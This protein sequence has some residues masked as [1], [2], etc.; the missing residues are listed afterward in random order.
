MS[1]MRD[2]PEEPLAGG[3]Q[4][5]GLVRVGST[6]RRPRHTQSEFV[7]ALLGHLEAVG[8][9]GAPRSLGYDKQGRQVLTYVEG[10]VPHATPFGLSDAQL[11]SATTLIR[12]YHDATATSA[13][14][15]GQEVVCHGDLGPH[16][17]VFRGD[18]AVALI[19]WDGDVQ[20]G[21]RAD[22]FAHAVWCFADLIEAAVPLAEQ[23]R[24]TRLMCQ[25][26]PGMTPSVVVEELG[27]RFQRARDRHMVAGRP[28]AAEIFGGLLAWL[29]EHGDDI[30]TTRPGRR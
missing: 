10:S 12:D 6:V 30:R 7:D 24:R 23:A 18:A 22:D 16:N 14:R 8:F 26:Y 17:T 13:L 3:A 9:S 29:D 15:D 27:A 11:L 1:D 21:R 28:R 4:T 2:E 19:D 20:P 5:P 25:A